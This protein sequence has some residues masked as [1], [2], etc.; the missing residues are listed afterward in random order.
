M[1]VQAGHD[2]IVNN[3]VRQLDASVIFRRR[4]IQTGC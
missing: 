4:V 2:E 3:A 1:T